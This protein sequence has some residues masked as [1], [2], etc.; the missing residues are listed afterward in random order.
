MV[1]Y[2]TFFLIKFVSADLINMTTPDYGVTSD[3]FNAKTIIFFIFS[4]Q[5][6]KMTHMVGSY[7]PKT[8]IQ[9]YLTPFEEAPSGEFFF[10]PK[11]HILEPEFDS[12]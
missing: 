4:F 10:H 12:V 8:E 2:W 6:D 9:S 1:V 7:P 3:I 11:L 5:V